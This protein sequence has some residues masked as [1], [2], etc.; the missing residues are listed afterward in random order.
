MSDLL[1][2]VFLPR[3]VCRL[4]TVGLQLP[5]QLHMAALLPI[6]TKRRIFASVLL[7]F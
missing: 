1:P 4:C 6:T 5:A 2:G 7:V 3:S